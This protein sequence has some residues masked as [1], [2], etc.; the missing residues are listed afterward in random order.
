MAEASIMKIIAFDQIGPENI[1]TD[2]VPERGINT[3]QKSDEIANCVER[4]IKK[5]P[6]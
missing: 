2:K 4:D 1:R 3:R 6:F 5:I